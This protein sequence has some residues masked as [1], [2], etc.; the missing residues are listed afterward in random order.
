MSSGGPLLSTQTLMTCLYTLWQSFKL[1]SKLVAYLLV[2]FPTT[3]GASLT[4]PKMG[5]W[6]RC[7]LND[8]VKYWTVSLFSHEVKSC[9]TLFSHTQ[10]LSPCL[11]MLQLIYSS[12][13]LNVHK[14]VIYDMYIY[15]YWQNITCLKTVKIL[16]V[17]STKTVYEVIYMPMRLI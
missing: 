10:R 7:L 17:L 8:P 1:L 12:K 9:P 11:A 15:S 16:N 13:N 14:V 6:L 4:F 2:V 3:K 5:V